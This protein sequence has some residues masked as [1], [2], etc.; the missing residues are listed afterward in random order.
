MGS[1]T[2]STR[3]RHAL[4][5][6][7]ASLLLAIATTRA[8][9]SPTT[10]QPLTLEKAIG[11]ALTHNRVL[12]RSALNVQSG[13][14]AI[15]AE[16][17]AFDTRLRPTFSY[18]TGDAGDFL[19]YG[20]AA[21]KTLHTG[22]TLGVGVSRSE[23]RLATG[24]PFGLSSASLELSQP[25]FRNM[26]NLVQDTPL[27]RAT[28]DWQRA[29]RRYEMQKADL[30]LAVVS[31]YE[32]VFRLGRQVGYDEQ[33]VTRT[34]RHYR[35]TQAK[36]ATGR[37]RRIDTL[38]AELQ[39]GEAEARLAGNR[40]RLAA[41]EQ[42]LAELIGASS[43][44]HYVLTPT[45]LPEYTAQA[46]NITL[47]T[48]LTNRLDYIQAGYDQAAATRELRLAKRQLLPDINLF[49]RYQ[50]FA[51]ALSPAE[52][53]AFGS[54]GLSVG[55]S[56]G[57]DA[58]PARART[59]VQQAQL[60]RAASAETV[61][62]VEQGIERQVLSQLQTYQQAYIEVDIAQRNLLLADKRLKLA[63]RLF[64]SGR[65]DSFSVAEAEN[66]FFTAESQWLSTKAHA[67]V[68]TYALAH[69]LG[70]LLEAPP[71]LKL[72]AGAASP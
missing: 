54:G 2:H 40:A 56:G 8:I 5:I 42:L 11:L 49:A 51:D 13:A 68:Q 47:E 65:G 1:I 12:N 71:E 4:R 16:E 37:T 41:G 57:F 28:Q 24:E 36:E 15:A 60:A 19:S 21:D 72:P 38:R 64:D 67:T 27:R 7:I 59:A 29:R 43:A 66:A 46:T 48:A 6:S 52:V 33:A 55:F 63:R 30:V 22:T 53:A 62:I 34:A 9:C 23:G 10:A 18:N 69:T 44:V 45:P 50:R 32:D 14:L 26:G 35:L 58:N 20:V 70:T 17:Q 31:Q 61:H 39:Q 25:L 3:V